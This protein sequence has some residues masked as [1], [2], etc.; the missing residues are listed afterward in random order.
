MPQIDE[1]KH[2]VYTLYSTWLMRNW[3][4]GTQTFELKPEAERHIRFF[5]DSIGLR[6]I[7]SL[8]TEAPVE[9]LYFEYSNINSNKNGS[10]LISSF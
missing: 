3:V 2:Q 10:D 8:L 6:E 7:R 4:I 1:I 5:N 9:S